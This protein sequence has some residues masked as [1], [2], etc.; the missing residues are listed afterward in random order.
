[1][2]LAVLLRNATE[3]Q[4][5][6][7]FVYA[8]LSGAANA[9][10]L[11]VVNKGTAAAAATEAS[12]RYFFLFLIVLA[13]YVV[14]QRFIFDR[15]TTIFESLVEGLRHRLSARIRDT[16]LLVF[17]R[18]TRSELYTRLTRE[19]QVIADQQMMLVGGIQATMFVLFAMV[20]IAFLSK[21]ALVLTIV[22]AGVGVWLHFGREAQHA[23]AIQ[24]ATQEEIAFLG[25]VGD[26][27]DGFTELKMD[28]RRAQAVG[29]YVDG[30]ATTLRWARER[31]VTIFNHRIIFAQTFFFSMVGA[32]VF[33]LPKLV[34]AY[35]DVVQQ[36]ATSVLFVVGPLGMVV[37]S[38][39]AWARASTAAA[40]ILRLEEELRAESAPSAKEPLALTRTPARVELR[41]VSFA[42]PASSDEAFS[43]GPLSLTLDAG[44][45]VFLVGG[46]GSGKSTLV[47]LLIGLY[48]PRSGVLMADGRV[49]DERTVQNYRE[50]FAAILPGFHLFKRLFGLEHA[51]AERIAALLAETKLT[52]K[53]AF[54]DGEFTTL[55]LSTGQR[56]RLALVVAL[57]SDKPFY[58][59]DEWA[60]DQ[61]P[62]YR[63]YFYRHVIADLKAAGR[64]VL[65]VTHDDRYFNIADRVL[66]ME[67][68]QLRTMTPSPTISAGS[69]PAGAPSSNA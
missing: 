4:R 44:E 45:V 12:T 66:R 6:H 58:V 25:A 43:V 33:I 55:D 27:L 10:I 39:P 35:A 1:M 42:Y 41:D 53:T 2:N 17:E 56:K 5:R 13:L 19:T 36:L 54:V 47:R 40:N 67:Y 20:Y 24:E 51:D 63:E 16:D 52:D 26:Q 31:M 60:A 57:L 69:L 64:G 21:V 23:A 28:H 68:G 3:E 22:C 32:V 34:H 65:V 37:N 48:G 30:H 18:H 9:G 46:N 61:D 15:A 62:E 14:T 38:F 50:Q 7:L 59:F 8:L 29:E 11:A 49:I